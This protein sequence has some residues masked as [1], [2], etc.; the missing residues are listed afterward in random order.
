[1]RV[2]VISDKLF[3]RSLGDGLRVHGLF[4][5][6]ASKHDFDL[7]CYAGNGETIDPD[8]QEVFRKVTLVPL[9][10]P[11]QGV[12]LA[13]RAIRA[14]SVREFKLTSSD[15][16]CAIEEALDS[17]KYD[18]LVDVAANAIANVPTNSHAV[19]IIVDSVD[20]PILREFRALRHA[21]GRGKARHLINAWRY[22]RYERVLLGRAAANVYASEVDASAY[23]RLFPGRK[24]AVVPNGVDTDFFCPSEL[25]SEYGLI[26]FEGNM[27]FGPNVD[28]ARRLVLEVLPRLLPLLPETRVY[29][30]GRDPDPLV[31]ELAS[32]RVVVTG[33]VAD[34]RP[35][36]ARASVF[37]CPMKLG[38]GIKNK[39]LQAWA[40]SKPVV[41]S[42]ESLGG[43]AARDGVN[44]LVRDTPEAFAEAVAQLIQDPELARSIAESGRQT[45]LQQYSWSARASQLDELLSDVVGRQ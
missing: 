28:A 44:L 10:T 4:G 43:L 34:V 40:M 29:L 11:V 8:L 22:W 18:L 27:H 5:P 26:A 42:P 21:S 36:L 38:S 33:T 6:L 16:R 37:V 15:M 1:M 20:E 12:S 2:L 14:L 31:Q 35:Y 13:L 24:V 25:D 23:Q 30:V 32:N 41:A 39:I 19:P 7:V 9:P 3:R 45:A 17:G